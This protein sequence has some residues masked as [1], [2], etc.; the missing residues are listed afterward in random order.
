MTWNY[1]KTLLLLVLT[2]AGCAQKPEPSP[3]W[4]AIEHSRC[5]RYGFVPGTDQYGACRI[6]LEENRMSAARQDDALR[7]QTILQHLLTR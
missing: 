7:R 6:Q 5:T 2:L 1:A 3:D 4:A